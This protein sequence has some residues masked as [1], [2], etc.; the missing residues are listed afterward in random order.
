[1]IANRRNDDWNAY[2]PRR[3]QG[4]P[5]QSVRSMESMY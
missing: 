4:N 2:D 5:K 1:M 3:D